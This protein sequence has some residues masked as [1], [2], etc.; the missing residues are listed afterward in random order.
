MDA[1]GAGPGPP[2]RRGRPP[3]CSWTGRPRSPPPCG[4]QTV[5][6]WR[7]ACR[8]RDSGCGEPQL[9]PTPGKPDAGRRREHRA[10]AAPGGPN[11]EQIRRWQHLS[12]PADH[13]TSLAFRADGAILIAGAR[14]GGVV[15]GGRWAGTLPAHS[16]G[17]A[18]RERRV[19]PGRGLGGCG[20]G[21]RAGI[22]WH[23]GMSWPTRLLILTR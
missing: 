8:T 21:R 22:L 23:P 16:R 9:A 2:T 10:N 19:Q 12:D 14:R 18:H 4:L 7:C 3:R 1:C 6:R 15:G 11:E 13:Y 17:P 5:K 20:P